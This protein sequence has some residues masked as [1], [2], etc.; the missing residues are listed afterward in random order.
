MTVLCQIEEKSF[1]DRRKPCTLSYSLMKAVNRHTASSRQ[2]TRFC[3][4]HFNR[5]QTRTDAPSS[6]D[7]CSVRD[8]QRNS[9][10]NH[11]KI[12]EIPDSHFQH[13]EGDKDTPSLYDRIIAKKPK[14]RYPR[15]PISTVSF[16]CPSCGAETSVWCRDEHGRE[17][18]GVC[19]ART[20]IYTT[21]CDRYA[22]KVENGSLRLHVMTHA[23]VEKEIQKLI[24]EA[25]ANYER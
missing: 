23:D 18:E 3:D 6:H 24:Q 19:E 20:A 25:I 2:R 22:E 9:N 16:S 15:P 14:N 8:R 10:L 7:G 4:R 12:V 21:V 11:N 5:S 17:T 1:T 13:D